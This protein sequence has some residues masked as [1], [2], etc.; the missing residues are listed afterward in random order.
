MHLFVFDVSAEEREKREMRQNIREVKRKGGK[1]SEKK[2]KK[3]RPAFSQRET[4]VVTSEGL[5]IRVDA[6]QSGIHSLSSLFDLYPSPFFSLIPQALRHWFG[7]SY[8]SRQL[9]TCGNHRGWLL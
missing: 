5:Q 2:K 3:S 7:R 6:A 4:L 8:R 1:R 9:K